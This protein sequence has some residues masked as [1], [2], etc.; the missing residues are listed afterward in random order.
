M[1]A[2]KG[3]IAAFEIGGKVGNGPFADLVCRGGKPTFVAI[4]KAAE[5]FA[6]AVIH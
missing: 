4:A 6:E 1:S 3:C 2:M 5:H